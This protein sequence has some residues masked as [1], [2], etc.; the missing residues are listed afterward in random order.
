[1]SE[2]EFKPEFILNKQKFVFHSYRT[3]QKYKGVNSV[4][5]FAEMQKEMFLRIPDIGNRQPI[6]KIVQYYSELILICESI[7]QNC[8]GKEIDNTNIS[9]VNSKLEELNG[10]ISNGRYGDFPVLFYDMLEVSYIK[11]IAITFNNVEQKSQAVSSY[12]GSLIGVNLAPPNS[13]FVYYGYTM[14]MLCKQ[15]VNKN[16]ELENSFLL[17][18]EESV[19]KL[20][21]Q[22][23]AFRS[24]CDSYLGDLTRGGEEYKASHI[25]WGDQYKEMM[26]KF[27]DEKTDEMKRLEALYQEKLKL[28]AP[29]KYWEARAKKYEQ[30]GNNWLYAFLGSTAISMIILLLVFYHYP[31]NLI[32]AL[33]NGDSGA[34][35]GVLLFATMISFLAYVTRLFNRL[36]L[37]AFH[38]KR[39]AEERE[40][41]T[42]V[43]LALNKDKDV[44]TE[45]RL[46]ILQSLFSRA[47]TGLLH[48]DSAP[49]M[50]SVASILT[51]SLSRFGK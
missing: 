11:E 15:I 5:K 46:L 34:I 7:I 18:I 37:S 19:I 22:T 25:S 50:P 14:A 36:S 1:M 39:D 6:V 23:S 2:N 48:G 17:N 47:D 29:V 9:I 26:Q 41:L 44:Q 20:S 40:Q 35:K 51:N 45:D 33:F 4:L 27:Y 28:E 31:E 13:Y 8:M 42:Y 16:T 32:G 43:Y 10:K 24:E 30:I 49:T 21:E 12:I 38:L 3:E